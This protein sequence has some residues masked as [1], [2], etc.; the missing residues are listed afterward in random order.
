[1]ANRVAHQKPSRTAALESIDAG[2]PTTK[3]A[4]RK[5]ATAKSSGKGVLRQLERAQRAPQGRE[6]TL[7]DWERNAAT[8]DLKLIKRLLARRH[9]FPLR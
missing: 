6:A 4:P 1:M 7:A 2:H 5:N 3:P 9:S 8:R